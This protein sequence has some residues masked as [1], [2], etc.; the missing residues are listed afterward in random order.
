[1]IK[2]MLEE[3]SYEVQKHMFPKKGNEVPIKDKHILIYWN[4]F[5]II[6]NND[7]YQSY[8]SSFSTSI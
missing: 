1:M 7:W 2:K 5:G 3:K 6:I 8:Q 4:D